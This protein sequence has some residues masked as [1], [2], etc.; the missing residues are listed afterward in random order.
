MRTLIE[1]ARERERLRNVVMGYDMTNHYAYRSWPEAERI[2]F[3]VNKEKA[4]IMLD[5]V[6]REYYAAVRS[7]ARFDP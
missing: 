6:E 3:D 2:E 1:L 4:R 7:A 5:E